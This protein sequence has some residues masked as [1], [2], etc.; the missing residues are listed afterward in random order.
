MKVLLGLRRA[1]M[2]A[3]QRGIA[4]VASPILWIVS[5]SSAMLSGRDNNDHLQRSSD[6]QDHERP[7]DRPDAAL[8]CRETCVDNAM[9]VA[10]A[11][12]IG[13]IMM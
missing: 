7:F 4:V 3:I 6:R 11:A 8:V 2:K 9:R 13:M 10:V 1:R 5:A 12:A